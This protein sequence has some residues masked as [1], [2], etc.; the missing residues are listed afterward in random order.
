VAWGG[1]GPPPAAP[2]APHTYTGFPYHTCAQATSS[3]GPDATKRSTTLF[4][5]ARTWV[6]RLPRTTHYLRALRDHW[7]LTSQ[8][9]ALR[10]HTWRHS[11]RTASARLNFYSRFS[12]RTCFFRWRQPYAAGR[13]HRTPV[14]GQVEPVGAGTGY[15]FPLTGTAEGGTGFSPGFYHVFTALWR[16]MDYLP[17]DFAFRSV[18]PGR[19]TT[20]AASTTTLPPRTHE[21][22]AA[23]QT[24]TGQGEWRKSA[25][26]RWRA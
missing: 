7:T 19:C 3:R 1:R 4:C 23:V 14:A 18:Y 10:R 11:L 24:P 8:Q 22:R 17:M 26:G 20:H 13:T 9:H 12:W 6:A 21:R 25:G 15:L 5:A 16:C 2:P